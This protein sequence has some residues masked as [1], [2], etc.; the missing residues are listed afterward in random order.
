M[1]IVEIVKVTGESETENLAVKLAKNAKNGMVIALEG[2]LGAGKTAFTKYFAKALGVKQ[3]IQSPTFTVVR[4]YAGE[5]FELH[6]FDVY[7][8]HD[9]DELFEIGFFEYIDS[10][11]GIC[12]VEWANLVRELLPEDALSIK[13]SYGEFENERIFEISH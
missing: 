12:I 10:K 13:I 6:H 3:V 11:K 1:D 9:E 2:E 8:V 4:S 5:K 7:R